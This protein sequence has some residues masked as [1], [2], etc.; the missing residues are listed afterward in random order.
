MVFLKNKRKL[1]FLIESY[2]FLPDYNLKLFKI[3]MSVLIVIS[4][5]L[6][7]N[8][9]CLLDRL[10]IDYQQEIFHIYNHY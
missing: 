9:F 3:L 4:F 1:E 5:Y 2:K 7:Y 6:F 8:S 10:L